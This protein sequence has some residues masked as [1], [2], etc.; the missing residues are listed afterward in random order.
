MTEEDVA[1]WQAQN[2]PIELAEGY[3]EEVFKPTPAMKAEELQLR[4]GDRKIP[5]SFA[6]HPYGF[7]YGAALVT[8]RVS[9][10]EDGWCVLEVA[11]ALDQVQI[12]TSKSG[13]MRCW[14]N[15]VEIT[16]VK[17]VRR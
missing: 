2:N 14:F 15:A 6:F 11:G 10:L 5:V 13:S 8:R 17:K 3:P 9:S 1:R 4:D 7:V 16:P 12:K